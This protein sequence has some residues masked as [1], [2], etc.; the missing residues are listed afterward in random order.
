MIGDTL[1]G[2]RLEKKLGEG[3]YGTVYLGRREDGEPGAV[4]VLHPHVAGTPEFRRRFQAE[5]MLSMDIPP[6][7]IAR[8]LKTGDPEARPEPDQEPAWV[9]TEYVEGRTLRKLVMGDGSDEGPL[10]EDDLHRT[11]VATATALVSIH[12]ADVVHR[13]FTPS[14]IMV[15]GDGVRVIDFGIARAVEEAPTMASGSTGTLRYMAPE[16][17][18]GTEVSPAIDVFAWGAV[19]AFAGTGRDVFDGGSAW[20]TRQRILYGEADLRGLPEALVGIVSWCLEKDPELRPTSHRLLSRLLGKETSSIEE[21]GEATQRDSRTLLDEGA[22]AFWRSITMGM[23]GF[24]TVAGPDREGTFEIA[25]TFYGTVAE[26]ARGVQSRWPEAHGML[27]DAHK[28]QELLRWL[29]EEEGKAREIV[30]VLPEAWGGADV[31]AANLVAELSPDLPALFRD[32]DMSWG[33]LFSTKDGRAW[34]YRGPE[35]ERLMDLVERHGLLKALS[36]HHCIGSDHSCRRERPCS[37][38][39]HVARQ[40]SDL[41]ERLRAL[42]GWLRGAA[43]TAGF[44]RERLSPVEKGDLVHMLGTHERRNGEAPALAV[45]ATQGIPEGELRE[46]ARRVVREADDPWPAAV[47]LYACRDDLRRVSERSAGP[48]ERSGPRPVVDSGRRKGGGRGRRGPVGREPRGL[49][50]LLWAVGAILMVAG[51]VLGALYWGDLTPLALM[52]AGAGAALIVIGRVLLEDH[53]KALT[54]EE[55]GEPGVDAGTEG[56]SPADEAPLG[57]E[58]RRAELLR[59]LFDFPE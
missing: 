54:R 1:G 2:Y 14:N 19:I 53:R 25:G 32:L 18:L 7:F 48:R 59:H 52:A 15:T 8:V 23:S 56:E 12:S 38:Y 31:Q 33:A 5:A 4:K 41:F 6:Y 46:R 22:A 26:L 49:S 9:V 43:A 57:D 34:P 44:D 45:W 47:A 40:A 58:E 30:G 16:Q 27:R 10:G 55:R 3:G 11:A 13:D 35:H 36:G 20:E 28:R 17:I 42:E 29:P 37:R 21:E 50:R 39:V 24:P 51:V